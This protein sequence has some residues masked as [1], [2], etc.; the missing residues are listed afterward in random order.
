M[1]LK[2]NKQPRFIEVYAQKHPV[3][4]RILV[5]IITGVNYLAMNESDGYGASG[6]LT[7]M[8]NPDGSVVVTPPET[9]LPK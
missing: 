1:A 5:D 4:L 3:R 8:R 7:V 9:F 6:G 2:S